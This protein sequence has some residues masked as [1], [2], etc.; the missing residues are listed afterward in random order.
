MHL[1]TAIASFV[2]L[3]GS[4]LGAE[5]KFFELHLVAPPQAAGVKEYP[6]RMRDGGIEMLKLE[7]SALMDISSIESASAT[8]TPK[9]HIVRVKLTETGAR[10]F[11]D[12]TAKHVGDQVAFVVEGKVQTAPRIMEAI[13]GGTFELS[14][15]FTW[16]EALELAAKFNREATR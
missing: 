6:H 15:N 4:L 12:I 2:L 8:P 3:A 1:N 5:P 10:I 9:G 16:E 7:S 13:Y 14:G 11:S